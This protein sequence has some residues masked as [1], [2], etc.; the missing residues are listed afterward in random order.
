MSDKRKKPEEMTED[1][2]RQEWEE[3]QEVD[4]GPAPAKHMSI[5][6]LRIDR[7]TLEGLITLGTKTGAGPTVVAREILRE[8]VKERIGQSFEAEAYDAMSRATRVMHTIL[9]G[10]LTMTSLN[11]MNLAC[12][13]TMPTT[14]WQKTESQRE[15][16]K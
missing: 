16:V 14:T 9:S 1:E 2:A 5:F 10:R 13:I 6:S 7:E 4:L 12:N 8:G 15:G 11:E 3:G